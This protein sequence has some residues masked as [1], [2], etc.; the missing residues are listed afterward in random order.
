MPLWL[1]EFGWP[2]TTTPTTALSP[3]F[4][5][6]A[7]YLS[8]AYEDLL[9]LPFVQ[10]A[11]VFNLED[12]SPGIISPDPSSSTTS[13]WCSTGLREAGRER[14]RAVREGESGALTRPSLK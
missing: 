2:G 14:V 12:Y 11:F 1:T 8:E 10:A 4:D 5:T 3:S 6:Q 13:A 9:G 7:R